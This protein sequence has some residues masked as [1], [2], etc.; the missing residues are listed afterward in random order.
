MCLFD[1]MP[2]PTAVSFGAIHRLYNGS[3][4]LHQRP[5]AHAAQWHANHR[6]CPS[7]NDDDDDAEERRWRKDKGEQRGHERRGY[8]W[9]KLSLFASAPAHASLPLSSYMPIPPSAPSCAPARLVRCHGRLPPI[10]LFPLLPLEPFDVPPACL[11]EV[12]PAH[13]LK[14]LSS[15]RHTRSTHFKHWSSTLYPVRSRRLRSARPLDA[16]PHFPLAPLDAMQARHRVLVLPDTPTHNRD[17]L[18]HTYHLGYSTPLTPIPPSS[19]RARVF[20]RAHTPAIG[21]TRCPAI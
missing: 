20:S 10:P 19:P 2:A 11:L 21:C 1:P 6:E 5:Y 16:T 13:P 12:P 4:P 17:L 7:V 3:V 14:Q 15:G 18:R 8:P 9:G